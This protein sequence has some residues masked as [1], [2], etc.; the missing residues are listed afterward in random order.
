MIRLL[1]TWVLLFQ[2]GLIY[3]NSTNDSIIIRGLG[4]YYKN[5]TIE[6]FAIE[7]YITNTEKLLQSTKTDTS[8]YFEFRFGK[9]LT[10]KLVIRSKKNSSFLFVQPGGNYLITI[11]EKNEYDEKNPNGNHVDLIFY[12]LDS[13]DINYKVLKFERWLEKEL[14]EF[15]HLKKINSNEYSKR[16][17]ELKK[18]ADKQ[19]SKDTNVYFLFHYKYALIELDDLESVT[20]NLRVQ[21]Y[22]RWFAK[23]PVYYTNVSYMNYFNSFYQSLLV[24]LNNN[25]KNNLYDAV[26][27]RS[28]SMAMNALSECIE[29]KNIQ[30]REL[31]MLKLFY[32]QCYDKRYPK[33]NILFMLD[34]IKN[35]SKIPEHRKIALNIIERVSELSLGSK[36]PDFSLLS[37]KEDTLTNHKLEGKHLYFHFYDPNDE[38][39]QID[40]PPLMKLHQLYG[41]YVQFVSIIIAN[42]N[43]S[44]ITKFPWHQVVLNEENDFIKSLKIIHYPRYMLLDATGNIVANPAMGPTPGNDYETIEPIFFQIKRIITG[45]RRR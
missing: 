35:K 4:S 21:N 3:S 13:L 38:K 40:L 11:G 10:Q 29:L 43:A 17:S 9:M 45:E 36:F 15:Y 33:T 1:L 44:N 39:S 34:S 23:F 5:S 41:E 7:D 26:I 2:V 16:Y 32:D 22:L 8:G 6:I 42:D 14:G 18:S 37:I 19:F 20:A 27:N 25:V 30:I 24:N 12:Q 28:P 31:A